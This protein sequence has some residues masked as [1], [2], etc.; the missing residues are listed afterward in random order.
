MRTSGRIILATLALV[1][2]THATA[3]D[4]VAEGMRLAIEHFNGRHE[5]ELHSGGPEHRFMVKVLKAVGEA[6]PALARVGEGAGL[7]SAGLEDP[8]RFLKAEVFVPRRTADAAAV[9]VRAETITEEVG[10]IVEGCPYRKTTVIEENHGAQD[11][12]TTLETTVY[13]LGASDGPQCANADVTR[14]L[15]GIG[16]AQMVVKSRDDAYGSNL[17]IYLGNDTPRWRDMRYARARAVRIE[18]AR[19]LIE[20]LD[21]IR[22]GPWIGRS[23]DIALVGSSGSA[24]LTDPVRLRYTLGWGDCPAGCIHNHHWEILVTPT[25]AGDGSIRFDV[26]VTGEQG[27]PL[28]GHQRP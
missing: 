4:V 5:M 13:S 10:R 19:P 9:R 12:H 26:V 27:A 8:Y 15:A 16:L 11:T 23:S 24:S 18:A 28:P 25:P 2:G 17:T 21:V 1:T 20:R 6:V 22:P 3:A 14:A 7:A